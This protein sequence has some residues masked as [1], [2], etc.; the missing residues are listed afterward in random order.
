MADAPPPPPSPVPRVRFTP[1]TPKSVTSICSDNSV[2][3]SARKHLERAL[4]N[5]LVAAEPVANQTLCDDLD[6]ISQLRNYQQQ[7]LEQLASVAM[8]GADG[9]D[10]REG[11]REALLVLGGHRPLTVYAAAEKARRRLGVGAT[12]RV[13]KAFVLIR[14]EWMGSSEERD[15]PGLSL[16]SLVDHDN[17]EEAEDDAA[18]NSSS[19]DDSSDATHVATRRNPLESSSHDALD[20]AAGGASPSLSRVG[21]GG[22]DALSLA[23]LVVFLLCGGAEDVGDGVGDGAAGGGVGGGAPRAPSSPPRHWKEDDDL[24]GGPRHT[25]W[26]AAAMTQPQLGRALRAAGV[27]PCRRC[28][29]LGDGVGGRAAVE[30]AAEAA[31]QPAADDGDDDPP[32][33]TTTTTA[34]ATATATAATVGA[35]HRAYDLDGSGLVTLREVLVFVADHAPQVRAMRGGG[36]HGGAV[37]SAR[38]HHHALRSARVRPLWPFEPPLVCPTVACGLLP[39]S[40]RAASCVVYSKFEV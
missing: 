40:P 14:D 38:A 18:A 20:L 9:D 12:A 39:E 34:T 6:Q 26:E 13:V 27:L 4:S 2:R 31:A 28:R 8:L 1:S 10:E 24:R 15:S 19:S 35:L 30:A 33:A 22:L 36:E 32:E 25:C 23:R 37:R 11:V 16:D 3:L 17:V 21:E 29:R 5:A 7:K